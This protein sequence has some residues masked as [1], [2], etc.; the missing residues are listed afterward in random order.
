MASALKYLIIASALSIVACSNGTQSS[1]T[2]TT[3]SDAIV[4]GQPV[5]ANS[6]LNSSIVGIYDEGVGA[7]CTGSLLPNNIVL[8]AA[9]CIGPDATKMYII[10]D[11][12]MIGLLQGGNPAD[13]RNLVRQATKAV[14]NPGWD[15]QT[16][17]QKDFDWHDIAVIKFRGTIPNGFKPATLLTD[18][19]Q[20]AQ[21]TTVTLAGYGVDQIKV[22]P[23]DPKTYPNLD[24]AIA[25]EEVFCSADK[26]ECEKVESSGAGVLRTTTVNVAENHDSEILLDQS[27]GRGACSGDSGGPAYIA[28]G[29]KYLLWG[30]TSRGT[31]GCDQDAIYTNALSYLDWINKTVAGM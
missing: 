18:A 21:G 19:T 23:V 25:K 11:A 22:T 26:S 13:I 31:V 29:G 8:T 28:Q 9:H 14:V 30:I 24:E 10:F 15:P 1:V 17:A 2:T 3:S 12:D 6:E 4:G 16:N 20:L 7:I 27:Q 5:V